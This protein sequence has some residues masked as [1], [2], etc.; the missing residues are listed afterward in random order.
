MALNSHVFHMSG[1]HVSIVLPRSS[2]ILLALFSEALKIVAF[3]IKQYLL[4]DT[5]NNEH[6]VAGCL[7]S[8]ESHSFPIKFLTRKPNL[9]LSA[10]QNKQYR[11]LVLV[12][13]THFDIKAVKTISYCFQHPLM[14][15]HPDL[16][17]M[18]K[19]RRL[20]CCQVIHH[21]NGKTY[22]TRNNL[23]TKNTTYTRRS[24]HYKARQMQRES[25]CSS[26]NS[27]CSASV[28]LL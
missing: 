2:L 21:R 26:I 3:E 25:T 4:Y 14:P 9:L 28:L 13:L 22:I 7:F 23:Q 10:P 17:R 19:P 20:S 11:G 5:N 12:Q 24:R 1:V 15:S 27:V 18:H 6:I 16:H 8:L